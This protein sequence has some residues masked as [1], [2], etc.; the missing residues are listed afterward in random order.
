[1]GWEDQTRT[2]V[3]NLVNPTLIKTNNRNKVIRKEQAT[4]RNTVLSTR[5]FSMDWMTKTGQVSHKP[6]VY[7]ISPNQNK[8]KNAN[9][10]V[11]NHRK[12]QQASSL[13]AESL[14]TVIQLYHHFKHKIYLQDKIH[15]CL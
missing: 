7:N 2:R 13:A 9:Q 11:E 12:D 3:I 6:T 8:T 1:M 14:Q 4:N 5:L 15:L 10:I